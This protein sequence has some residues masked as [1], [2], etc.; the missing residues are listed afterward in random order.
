MPDL[1][2]VRVAVLGG[3]LRELILI[4]ELLKQG[5]VVTAAGYP[6]LPDLAGVRHAACVVDAIREQDAV[7]A[8]MANTDEQGVIRTAFDAGARLIL[9]DAAFQAIRPGTPLF[10]GV[11]KPIIEKLARSYDVRLIQL[12]EVDEIAILN[13]IPTAEGAIQRAMETLPVTLHGTRTAVVGFGRCGVTL[14]RM[15]HG[16]GSRVCVVARDPGQRARAYEMGLD[17]FDL[18]ELGEAV[19]SA[20]AVFNTI[21]A[22]VLTRAVLER[23]PKDGVVIDIASAP[24]G[25]DFEAARELGLKAFLD[26]GIPGKAAPETAGAILGRIVP[27]LIREALEASR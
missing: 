1:D 7:I 10:I 24:G 3:D 15:L 27:G 18:E 11:A 22:G 8:P 21:P 2:G 9:D 12:A 14:A 26:L 19:S 13:S 25:T 16:I 4:R 6:D 17:A 5:A 20:R 23:I